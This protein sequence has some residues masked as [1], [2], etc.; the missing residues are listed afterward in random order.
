MRHVL[1][2]VCLAVCGM[3]L[4]TQVAGLES[5]YGAFNPFA[6][7]VAAFSFAFLAASVWQLKLA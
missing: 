6:R 4:I 2:A 7:I 1:S 3:F 5:T